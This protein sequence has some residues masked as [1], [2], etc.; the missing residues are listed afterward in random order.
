MPYFRRAKDSNDWMTIIQPILIKVSKSN[1]GASEFQKC[2]N[3]ETFS[4]HALQ[5]GL[6]DW[7]NLTTCCLIEETLQVNAFWECKIRSV[8]Q[9]KLNG[10]T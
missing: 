9:S 8:A 7:F 1:D 4:A 3:W 2:I 6:A 5:S 10:R